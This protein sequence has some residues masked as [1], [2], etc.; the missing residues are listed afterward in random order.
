M[1]A[2]RNRPAARWLPVRF[3][4][5]LF[6]LYALH[7]ISKRQHWSETAPVVIVLEPDQ[8]FEHFVVAGW[9]LATCVAELA[10]AIPVHPAIAIAVA[11]VLAPP[12]MHLPYFLIGGALLREGNHLRLHSGVTFLLLSIASAATCVG[13]GWARP[14]GWLFF[15]VL[16]INAVAAI[17]CL[18]LRKRFE[19]IE[20]ELVA[21]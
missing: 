4:Y 10:A 14:A 15:I 6:R 8:T 12:L 21:S 19:A 9:L 13:R 3:R 17:L 11:T 18:V 20:R 16:A 5:A 7:R 2:I 1:N